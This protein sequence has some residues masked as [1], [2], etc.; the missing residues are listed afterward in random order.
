[1]IFEGLKKI[2]GFD[3]YY[4]DTD[5]M[6]VFSYSRGQLVELTPI[7]GY[8]AVTYQLYKNGQR[9]IIALKDIVMICTPSA[10]KTYL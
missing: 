6:K 2:A 5:S 1:M 3:S 8:K 4:L 10:S 7:K 9:H